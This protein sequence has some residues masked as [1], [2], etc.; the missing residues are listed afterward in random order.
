MVC[1][2]TPSCSGHSAEAEAL[3]YNF[4]KRKK[5]HLLKE[6]F[7]EERCRELEKRNHFYDRNSLLTMFEAVKGRLSVTKED[8]PE[9]GEQENQLPVKTE[10]KEESLTDGDVPKNKTTK[11]TPELA[12]FNY[13]HERQQEGALEILFN[14]KTRKEYG[15]KVENMGIGMPLVRRMYAHYRFVELKKENPR[16]KE[17]WKCEVCKKDF[18]T[19]G[20]GLDLLEHLGLHENIP[21]PCII[22]GC[23]AT[24]RR[25]NSL[26]THLRVRLYSY[27]IAYPEIILEKPPTSY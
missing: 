10:I 20:G 23:D 9:G 15:R 3:V 13:F 19:H 16:S 2:A 21:S 14:E 5:P 27:D 8:A 17:I 12:V 24:S 6:M 4:V 11:I 25:P 22:E 18:K 1:A 7:G 26:A